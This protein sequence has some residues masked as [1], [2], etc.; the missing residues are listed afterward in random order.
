MPIMPKNKPIHITYIGRLEKEKGIELIID[1]IKN[2]RETK[3]NIIWNICGDGSYIDELR[4]L[5]KYEKSD[6]RI[7]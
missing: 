6:I 1:C 7:Y 2:E 3:R 4:E 5:G